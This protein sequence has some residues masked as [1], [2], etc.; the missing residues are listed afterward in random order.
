MKSSI[1]LLIVILITLSFSARS[2]HSLTGKKWTISE[3]GVSDDMK[4][5]LDPNVKPRIIFYSKDST[6]NKLDYSNIE[7][8][9]FNGGTFQAKNIKGVVYNGVWNLNATNDTL[10]TDSTGNR[11]DF[12]NE[13]N[14]ITNNSTTQIIDT[15]GTLDTLYSYIKLYGV[16]DI[17]SVD[18]QSNSAVKV[19]PMPVTEVLTVELPSKGYREARL[20]NLF[21]QLVGS[22]SLQN[23]LS[24]QMAILQELPPGYYSLEIIDKDDNRVVKKVI[25]K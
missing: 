11:F 17:T 13:F 4:Y 25:K 15:I 9:F 7:M 21:G 8:H 10:V 18:E 6:T 23:K 22:F 12:I 19:Y 16:P 14:F 2:Q 20:Y 3:A 1:F 24:F 5:G